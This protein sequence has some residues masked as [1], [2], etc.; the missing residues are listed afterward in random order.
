MK[1]LITILI[2]LL[3]LAPPLFA[4][5]KTDTLVM[6]NGDRLTCEIKGL[7]EGVLY[8]SLDYILGTSSVQWSK[9][10]YLESKQLFI[11]KTTDGSV[12]TGTLGTAE[13]E[14][15]RPVQIEV[16]ESAEKQTALPRKE[17]VKIAETSESFWRRFNGD[18]DSGIIY[19]KGNQTTQYSL[20]ADLDYLRQRWSANGSYNSTLSSSSG[21]SSPATRNQLNLSVCIFCPGITTFT[22]GWPL[23]CKVRNKTS[24][25]KRI[26]GAA[27]AVISRTQTTH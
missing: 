20:G 15:K 25:Y 14:D 16:M 9:V 27:L 1:S 11:V 21:A 23:F 22:R 17:I 26:S 2:L 3:F 6:K 4:R 10:A 13:T 18:L 7:Q 12:Y 8:V 19:S 24:R 5:D